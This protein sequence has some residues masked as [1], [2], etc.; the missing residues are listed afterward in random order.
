M[1]SS[2]L[3]GF[4]R[5]TLD[6]RI[7]DLSGGGFLEEGGAGTLRSGGLT[8]E[9]AD[10]LTENVVGLYAL[11]FSIAPNFIINGE[12]RLITMSIEEPS[13]VAAASNA[14]RLI[15]ESGG[16]HAEIESHLMTAQV[17]ICG[18]RDT[19]AAV[20]NLIRK[21]R[22]I[23]E[24]CRTNS[25][26]IEDFGGGV[27]NIDVRTV[28]LDRNERR[29][30]V[31]ILVDCADAMGANTLNT[32]AEKSSGY[33][34]D[35]AGGEPGLKILTNLADQRLVKSRCRVIPDILAKYKGARETGLSSGE[36]VR[37]RVIKAFRLADHDPYR[38]ATHNKGIM[39]GID[40]VLLA[41]G[42][43]WRAVEAGAHAFAASTGRYRSLSSWDIG[44][45]GAL[46]GE[47]KMPMAIGI[48][49]GMTKYHGCAD[50]ALKIMGI[51]DVKEL[52]MLIVSVG[53]ATNLA[54]M[55]A[56]ATEGIQRG[57]MRLHKRH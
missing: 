23:I 36:A 47:L 5:K 54:A 49:G 57:H 17:E 6:Q 39:N 13:V 15:R 9:Q 55:L 41:T 40:S 34:A 7:K 22:N 12:D 31:H 11:P 4:Y 30:V 24:V 35:I 18:V 44:T 25:C 26:D 16:F 48:V 14:A 45:D 42:N 43:D 50:L 51:S 38:A 52:E 10:K 37:D 27:K 1:K 2:R 28:E 29:I 3:S 53:L 46:E 20:R 33:I 32:I 19:D 8:L 56:L 21:K